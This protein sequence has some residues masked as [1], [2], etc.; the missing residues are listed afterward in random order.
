[1]NFNQVLF[2]VR[3]IEQLIMTLLQRIE[4]LELERQRTGALE[5]TMVTLLWRMDTLEQ[6]CHN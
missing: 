1:V 2:K 6:E 5:Q 3:G 4:T